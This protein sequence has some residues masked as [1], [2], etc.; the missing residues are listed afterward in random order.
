M[1]ENHKIEYEANK[2]ALEKARDR[3]Q[4]RP[5][6]RSWFEHLLADLE[7]EEQEWQERHKAA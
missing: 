4:Q 2:A 1:H 3:F 5:G 7:Q 6:N